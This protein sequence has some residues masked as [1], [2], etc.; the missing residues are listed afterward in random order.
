MLTFYFLLFS[1]DD[2]SETEWGSFFFL[3][4]LDYCSEV[5][6]EFWERKQMMKVGV[7]SLG[8]MGAKCIG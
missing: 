5:V 3:G 2:I 7:L 1:L 4:V 8:T 6:N